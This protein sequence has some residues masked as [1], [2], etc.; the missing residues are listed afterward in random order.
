MA[1]ALTARP[2]Y[3]RTVPVSALVRA[4]T[5]CADRRWSPKPRRSRT[6]P[7]LL[8]LQDAVITLTPVLHHAARSGLFGADRG[9][10]EKNVGQSCP[11][12]RECTGNTGV[13]HGAAWGTAG[14][15]ESPTGSATPGLLT[16]CHPVRGSAGD[17]ARVQ[18]EPPRRT[19]GTVE[20]NRLDGDARRRCRG[21]PAA[22]RRKPGSWCWS[23]TRTAPRVTVP[24]RRAAP[25]P[26]E[27]ATVRRQPLRRRSAPLVP[28]QTPAPGRRTGSR[29]ARIGYQRMR[30]LEPA[31]AVDHVHV[32]S[33]TGGCAPCLGR[34]STSAACT[35]NRRL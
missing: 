33:P 7:T 12:D 15:G 21:H 31:D 2:I 24:R 35:G 17:G 34:V 8:L 16:L 28:R 6:I 18:R 5:V 30:A 14:A 1:W 32:K 22:V 27:V 4:T 20:A 29:R 9:S 13:S 23:P 19:E 10:R 26:P 3:S 11:G 25:G